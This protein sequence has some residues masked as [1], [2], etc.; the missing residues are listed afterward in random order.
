MDDPRETLLHRTE[1]LKEN[2]GDICNFKETS[3]ALSMYNAPS[4]GINTKI[5]GPIQVDAVDLSLRSTK[6]DAEG[7]ENY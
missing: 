5:I 7:V 3:A 2:Y 4:T 1:I 6:S